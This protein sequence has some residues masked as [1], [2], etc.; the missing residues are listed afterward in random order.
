MPRADGEEAQALCTHLHE[1]EDNIVDNDP[2]RG[3][4]LVSEEDLR[5]TL[6]RAT[7]AAKAARDVFLQAKEA[8]EKAN[9]AVVR[10]KWQLKAPRMPVP[11]KLFSHDLVVV[12]DR[13]LEAARVEA[14]RVATTTEGAGA[15]APTSK[16]ETAR[17]AKQAK[18]DA[19]AGAKK[20]QGEQLEHWKLQPDQRGE[21]SDCTCGDRSRRRC[22][23]SGGCQRQI[24]CPCVSWRKRWPGRTVTSPSST[25]MTR[26]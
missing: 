7:D 14:A 26:A 23:G 25:A 1:G 19:K 22:A 16:L 11:T 20:Q 10:I 13:L 2:V 17:K 18:K 3:N 9:N 6:E 12:C 15:A 4:G 5:D 24:G 21:T 8:C